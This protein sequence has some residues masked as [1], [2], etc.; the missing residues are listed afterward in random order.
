MASFLS[1]KRLS[2]ANERKAMNLYRECLEKE[3]LS[4]PTFAKDDQHYLDNLNWRSSQ[5]RNV[6]EPF[7]YTIVSWRLNYKRILQKAIKLSIEVEQQQ[8]FTQSQG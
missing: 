2:P 4:L 5:Q 7:N 1:G 6:F 8:R 3:L